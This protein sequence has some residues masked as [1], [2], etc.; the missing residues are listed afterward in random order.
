MASPV[1]DYYSCVSGG[2]IAGG[3]NLQPAWLRARTVRALEEV[4]GTSPASSGAA[5]VWPG[6]LRP[7]GQDS[8]VIDAW[9]G[10]IFDPIGNKSWFTGTGHSNGN[11][12]HFLVASYSGPNITWDRPKDPTPYAQTVAYLNGTVGNCA[13][14]NDDQTPTGAHIYWSMQIIGRKIVRPHYFNYDGITKSGYQSFAPNNEAWMPMF[15]IDAN[16]WDACNAHA[17]MPNWGMDDKGNGGVAYSPC[18]TDGTYYYAHILNKALGYYCLNKYDPTN[19]TWT[20]G[21]DIGPYSPASGTFPGSLYDSI[22][23]ELVQL[24]EGSHQFVRRYNLTTL[25]K[26]ETA[27]TGLSL[28]A[29]WNSSYTGICHD[30]KRDLYYAYSGQ[31]A[32]DKHLYVIDPN[33]NYRVSIMPGTGT[34]SQTVVAGGLNSRMF[35][36]PTY[37]CVLLLG[38]YTQNF[39][40]YRLS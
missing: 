22:R 14:W 7:G 20:G 21:P 31:A 34:T 4:P 33:D 10:S 15:D 2:S 28:G 24:C 36:H 26:T 11:Y 27:Y 6:G 17:L 23:H 13:H 16:A 29:T 40:C 19:E 30:T 18:C 25:T 1:A 3:M 8:D 12:N 5:F 38:G 32:T 9:G 37:D 39:I 35:Y